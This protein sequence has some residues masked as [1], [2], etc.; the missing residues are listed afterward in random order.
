MKASLSA[1]K[2]HEYQSGHACLQ[3]CLTG[4]KYVLL[5]VH[6]VIRFQHA[7]IGFAP[8]SITEHDDLLNS[9]N[10]ADH[11]LTH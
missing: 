4:I 1:C 5:A 2:S 8:Q 9:L 10:K 6:P 7:V 3:V 11:V